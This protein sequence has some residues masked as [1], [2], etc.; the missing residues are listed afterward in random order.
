MDL[1][2]K[3]FISYKHAP[4]DNVVAA[5]IQKR[6]ERYHVPGA[7]RKKTG[8]NSIGRIFRDKDEL[9][10]TSD[11]S[12]DIGRALEDADFLIVICSTSTKLSA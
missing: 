11:L 7:I 8:K 6:L 4:A 5:E 10:I 2:Y 1:H 12:D 3:A 9:P